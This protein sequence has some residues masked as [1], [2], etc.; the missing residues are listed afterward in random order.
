MDRR[1]AFR[2]RRLSFITPHSPKGLDAELFWIKGLCLRLFEPT[3]APIIQQRIG[4]TPKPKTFHQRE[5]GHF[6]EN[7]IRNAIIKFEQEFMGR[8]PED[9]RA[10]HCPGSRG[11]QA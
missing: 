11:G 4:L 5:I 2:C 3:Y 6:V 1:Q 10:F 8:G 9:V 7:A